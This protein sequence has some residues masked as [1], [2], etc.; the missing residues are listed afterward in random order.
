M[1]LEVN[2]KTIIK[3]I[4]IIFFLSL[5][6][7]SCKVDKSLTNEEKI[8]ILSKIFSDSTKS[9][10]FFKKCVFIN[11][12]ITKPHNMFYDEV[13]FE[14]YTEYVAKVLNESDTQYFEQQIIKN[15]DLKIR[16]LKQYGFKFQ[17]LD[18]KKENTN[19]YVMISKPLFNKKED[20]FY[21]IIQDNGNQY[22]YLFRKNGDRWVMTDKFGLAIE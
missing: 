11:M 3:G 7:S 18:D 2:Y 8:S 22:Q 20:S 19:C 1:L 13:F 5:T 16:E 6:L 15:Q 10:L 21:I 4:S 14:S 17:K 9:D 12:H